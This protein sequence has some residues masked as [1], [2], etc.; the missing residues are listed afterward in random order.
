[1]WKK[2]R[3]LA[4]PIKRVEEGIQLHQGKLNIY[5]CV[6]PPAPDYNYTDNR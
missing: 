1:M 5:K 3:P 6:V 4:L 2:L